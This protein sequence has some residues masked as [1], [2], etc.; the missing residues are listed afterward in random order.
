MARPAAIQDHAPL[1]VSNDAPPVGFGSAPD[2][3]RNTERKGFPFLLARSE[4]FPVCSS[5]RSERRPIVD[6]RERFSTL[7]ASYD[8]FLYALVCEDASGMRLSVIS[9]LART[10]VDPWKEAARLAA[11]PKAIAEKTLLSALDRVSG[12]SWKSPEA[13]VIAAR[14]VR[15]LPQPG[16]AVA[17]T[18]PATS[19]AAT[20]APKG[21]TPLTRYWWIWLGFWIAM[22]FMVPHDHANTTNTHVA[23][24]TS[25]ATIP[26]KNSRWIPESVGQSR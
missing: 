3:Q 23:T 14:V 20:G 25:G 4:T 13:A 19:N 2:L 21:R 9:V 12:R 7:S 1:F 22:S 26:L 11:M 17:T 24:S 18:A 8:D 15:L 6:H 5:N 16:R 10:N